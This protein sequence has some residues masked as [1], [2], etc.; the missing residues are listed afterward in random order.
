[1]TLIGCR[2]P[3]ADD[4]SWPILPPEY[5]M[6]QV[7]AS[8]QELVCADCIENNFIAD[9]T[10]SLG[11][12]ARCSYCRRGSTHT[13]AVHDVFEYVYMSLLQEYLDPDRE[14]QR[15]DAELGLENMSARLDTQDVLNDTGWPLG[16]DTPL[17]QDFIATFRH[18]WTRRDPYPELTS[19]LSVEG[20]P[21]ITEDLFA[22][23]D[24]VRYFYG[25]D[26][27][28]EHALSHMFEQLTQIHEAGHLRLFNSRASEFVLYRAR[29]AKAKTTASASYLGS[30]PPTK[31]SYQR[32]T[33]AGETGF[34]A[35]DDYTTALAEARHQGNSAVF[36]GRWQTTTQLRYADLTG[37]FIPAN[38]FDFPK[39]QHRTAFEFL[40]GFQEQITLP[41]DPRQAEKLKWHSVTHVVVEFLQELSV[42]DP[43]SRLDAIKYPSSVSSRGANWLLFGRPDREN[44]P[45]IKLESYRRHD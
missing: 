40:A 21:V 45:R 2:G 42:A 31:A 32:L 10:A 25:D 36:V 8:G 26:G 39:S 34:Y 6:P 43:G 4:V 23:R 20:I 44:P 38:L 17:C 19:K 35:A 14:R 15:P 24:F 12:S 41:V 29:A 30:P 3:H 37:E 18:P 9:A 5:E 7:L 13:A 27:D 11:A 33:K 16:D 28:D 1:M 22:D